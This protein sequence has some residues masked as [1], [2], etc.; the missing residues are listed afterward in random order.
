MQR[1]R[2]CTRRATGPAEQTLGE[3]RRYISHVVKVPLKIITNRLH[4]FFEAKDISP[5]GQRGFQPGRSPACMI[6]GVRRLQ[7][8]GRK[9]KIPL[10]MCFMDLPK[11]YD[12]ADR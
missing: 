1:S 5:E 7:E 11:A 12:S 4:A 3:S 6:F 8:L 2:C 9:R 10:Y